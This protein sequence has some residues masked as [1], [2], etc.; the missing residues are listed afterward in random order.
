MAYVSQIQYNQDTDRYE[1]NG[2][3]LHCGDCFEVL[4][5]NGLTNKSEWIET[6]IENN[7]DGWY[8]IGLAGYQ[9]NGLFARDLY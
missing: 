9:I 6:K 4:V 1:M 5:F 3:E 8:L 2:Y 7:N